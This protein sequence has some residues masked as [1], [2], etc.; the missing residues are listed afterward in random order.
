MPAPLWWGSGQRPELGPRHPH[1]LSAGG[2][3]GRW[4]K[5]AA[6]P[7]TLAARPQMKPLPFPVQRHPSRPLCPTGPA[8]VLDLRP[9]PL[10]RSYLD[11]LGGRRPLLGAASG[12]VQEEGLEPAWQGQ[13]VVSGQAELGCRP[14]DRSHTVHGGLGGGGEG[15][16]AVLRAP[17]S[18]GLEAPPQTL[19]L[20][21]YGA[22]GS[23]PSPGPPQFPLF[24]R[25]RVA[26]RAARGQ[27][28]PRHCCAA[29]WW[30]A[31]SLSKNAGLLVR[32]A[33][34]HTTC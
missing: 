22:R 32:R 31:G 26:P 6:E 24:P 33:V 11:G 2:G 13:L 17:P 8:R 4:G 27:E 16:P 34:H 1:S 18:P 5:P 14:Q 30:T 9:G 21:I 3:S 12:H 28:S 25:V 15:G 7:Q 23:K 10:L 19:S 29:K 20:G